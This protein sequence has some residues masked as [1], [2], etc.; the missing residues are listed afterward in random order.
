MIRS[1]VVIRMLLVAAFLFATVVPDSLQAQFS[2]DIL[3]GESSNATWRIHD[4]IR[5]ELYDRLAGEAF[6]LLE[7]RKKR[8][9]RLVSREAFR[10]WR[11]EK[12]ATL[13]RIVGPFPERTPL[14]TEVTGRIEREGYRVEN[15]IYESR[16]GFRVT[17]SLFTP[18]EA[19]RT[20]A[21]AILYVSGHTT[22][23]YRYDPYQHLIL[24]LVHKGFV[25]LAID[26]I[27]QGERLEYLNPESGES[28]AGGPTSEHAMPG[29]QTLIS[30]FSLARTMIWDGIR[31]IDLLVEQESV[32][33]ARIGITGMSGGGTQTALIAAIDDRIYASAPSNY[34]TTLTRLFQTLGPQDDE[35][36]L[37]H[38]VAE[39]IDHADLLAV[40]APRPV[41]IASTTNDFFAIQGARETASELRRLYGLLDA[42]PHVSTTEDEAGHAVTR[43][44]REAIY[45][46][47]QNHL[48]QPGS[49]ND[50]EVNV[51]SSDLLQV[52]SSGHVALTPGSKS[53]S[54]INR[55]E[56]EPLFER[57]REE[58]SRP[59]RHLA[60]VR[61]AARTF[62]GYREPLQDL[63]PV[64]AGEQTRDGYRVEKYLITGES[65][66]PIPFLWFQPNRPNGQGVLWV[67][68]EGKEEWGEEG[69][70]PDWL[71]KRGVSVLVPDLAGIGELG[72]ERLGSLRSSWRMAMLIRRS[73][74]G[75]QAADLVSLIRWASHKD[76]VRQ[77]HGVARGSISP[78]LL[79]AALMDPT[80]QSIQIERGLVSWRDLVSRHDYETDHVLFSVPA[81]L[82]AYDLP[83]LV[84]ALAPTPVTLV[85]PLR[86]DGEP[87]NEPEQMLDYGQ[88]DM[89]YES[90]GY[91][92][93]FR[94]VESD[95]SSRERL[96]RSW[97]QP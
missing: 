49:P 30:G 56:S 76:G 61:S 58:R 47:F 89:Y 94:I 82:R 71:A 4:D 9:D 72:P 68:P 88:V 45:D 51:L 46:F 87:T 25:V 7:Q 77:L 20:P 16:P 75:A 62:S 26:P 48:D 90:M 24:N 12:R 69:K 21:P 19:D 10:Q 44:N 35:Q 73:I 29:A 13:E 43:K 80:L 97:I 8:S 52:T 36:N 64:F 34:I 83:D 84:M 67:T 85:Q 15:L 5:G 95:L 32:D 14:N 65:G 31:G 3:D 40:R 93:H 27:G 53:S 1:K 37:L 79:H 33:P 92:D 11:E 2:L 60:N 66:A 50:L 42:S 57:L 55:E 41:M 91:P 22:D 17:G 78:T 86:A 59:D 81:A 18:E 23:A 38:G 70:T 63:N 6:E 39:G 54:E 28:Y 74:A 96:Y